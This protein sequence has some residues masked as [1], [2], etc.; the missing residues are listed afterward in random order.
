MLSTYKNTKII[1]ERLRSARKEKELTLEEVAEKLGYAQYQTISN[2]ENGTVS[3]S[4]E[5][6]LKLCNFYDCEIGYLVGEFDCKKREVADIQKE[7]G[8]SEQAITNLQAL[9]IGDSEKSKILDAVFESQ[10]FAAFVNMLHQYIKDN[11]S[12]REIVSHLIETSTHIGR[13][14]DDVTNELCETFYAD[15]ANRIF[16][17]IVNEYKEEKAVKEYAE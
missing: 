17:K 2:Y 6:T 12:S 14:C 7:I 5:V 15:C 4:L 13:Y 1:G 3:P 11:D 8:L 9:Q 16:W 10:L